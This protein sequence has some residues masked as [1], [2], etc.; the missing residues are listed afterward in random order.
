MI[1]GRHLDDIAQKL[2]NILPAGLQTAKDDLEK[3]LKLWLQ[4]TLSQLNFVSRD[5]FDAQTKV[6]ARTRAK[7]DR[8]EQELAIIEKK[9]ADQN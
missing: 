5:E 4:S 7:L 1:D 8:L 3:N 6:L 9:I 2:I